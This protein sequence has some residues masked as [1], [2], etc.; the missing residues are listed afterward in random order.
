MATAQTTTLVPTESLHLRPV[1]DESR[2]QWTDDVPPDDAEVST[3]PPVDRG[4]KAY[5]FLA[6]CFILEALVWGE[7]T[8]EPVFPT[9]LSFSRVGG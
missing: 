4:R 5:A 2:A 1:I 6:A 9:P 3:L 8:T 7:P